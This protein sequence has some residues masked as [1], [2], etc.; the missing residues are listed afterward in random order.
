MKTAGKRPILISDPLVF[1]QAFNRD[2]LRR[3]WTRV[4]QNAGAAGGDRVTVD[5]F[6]RGVVVRL[7]ELERELTE[8]RYAP[9]PIRRVTIPKDSGGTRP[10]DIPC[11]RDRV[12]QTAL[13]TALAP[14]LDAEF[15]DASFAYRAGRSV[16]QAVRRVSYLRRLGLTYVV[17]ADIRRYF[18]MVS[19]DMLMERLGESMSDGPATEL[20]GLW[21]EHWAPNGRGL[22]QGSPI[23]PLLANLYLDRLDEKLSSGG[24]RIVR[25]A[26]DF[27]VLCRSERGAE[28]ALALTE[29]LLARHGLELNREKTRVTDFDAGFRF[30]GHAFVRSFALADPHGDMDD[31]VAA[32]RAIARRDA[33]EAE[34]AAREE[35]K[36]DRRKAA[37][38]DP[39]QRVL[40]M[41]GAGRRLSLRN[42]GFL[43]EE[44]VLGETPDGRPRGQDWRDLLVVHPGDVDRIEIGPD[45]LF[46]DEALRHALGTETEIAFVNGHGETLGWLTRGH[47]GRARRHLAQAAAALDKERKL[48]FAKA[49]VDGR[50]RNQRALLRRLNHARKREAT[51]KALAQINHL[52]RRIVHCPDIDTLRGLEGRATALYWPCFGATLE[53]GFGLRTRDRERSASPVNI[54]LNMT[55]SLLARDVAVA[56]AR[57][58]LHTGFGFLHEA[59][60]HREAAVY[61]L[62]EEFRAPLAEAAVSTAINQ[63]VVDLAQFAPVPGRTQTRMN[64]AAQS[65]LIRTYERFAARAVKDPATGRRRSWRAL[66]SDQAI[67]LAQA[68]ENGTVY[69]SFRMDY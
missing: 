35:E 60:D 43:V 59:G 40:Y 56:L 53:H 1:S 18:E 4:W 55:A 37:G 24:A 58:G 50:M 10:L 8:G 61:D 42:A 26:D 29:R 17:D 32:L 66:I 25:F 54:M 9:G 41:I 21:L 69:Q 20:V 14:L 3:A 11:V 30:L 68:I 64:T 7:A 57:A 65:A 22:A 52:I 15:E 51:I 47:D 12:A 34:R 31:T 13:N 49:F 19:H 44:S 67:R 38:L 16:Q 63:R 39:G 23:S 28:Q 2:S 62:M 45:T 36:Q 27:V 33:G 48:G 46:E 6:A 5:A